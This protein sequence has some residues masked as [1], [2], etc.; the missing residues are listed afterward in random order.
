MNVGDYVS[1]NSERELG[2]LLSKKSITDTIANTY[3]TDWASAKKLQFVDGVPVDPFPEP[4]GRTD[5]CTG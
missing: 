3:A 1:V 5:Y 2:I 4:K